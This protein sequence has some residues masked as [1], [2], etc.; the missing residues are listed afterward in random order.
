MKQYYN[1]PL[2]LKP[3][4]FTHRQI[5]TSG[6]LHPLAAAIMDNVFCFKNSEDLLGSL[7]SMF[8]SAPLMQH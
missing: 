1:A 3:S 7:L 2:F 5:F 4:L 6:V 8:L